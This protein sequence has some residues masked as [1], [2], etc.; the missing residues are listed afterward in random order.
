MKKLNKKYIEVLDRLEWSKPYYTDDGRAEIGK[1]SPAG[2]DFSICV[3]IDDFPR[4]VAEY[5][6]D[7]DTE[8]H[9]EMWIEAKRNG[10]AGV[11]SAYE[12]AKDADAIQEML[13]E[14][15][16]ELCCA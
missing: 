1:Y 2:E 12:L 3:E 8:E 13:D 6:A 15:A 11:P 7:F 4:S 5:A 9:V 10:F 14:L 16:D